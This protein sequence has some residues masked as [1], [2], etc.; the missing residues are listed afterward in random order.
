[1]LENCYRSDNRNQT[2]FHRVSTGFVILADKTITSHLN[3]FQ[4]HPYLFCN[5]LHRSRARVNSKGTGLSCRCKNLQCGGNIV[6]I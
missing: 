6:K 1:M 5:G 4:L 2:C 3:L